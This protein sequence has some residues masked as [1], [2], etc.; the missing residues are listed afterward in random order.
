[1]N[2]I[3]NTRTGSRRL[4]P[5]LATAMLVAGCSAAG[6]SPPSPTTAPS[7]TS[8]PGSSVGTNPSQPPSPS[9]SPAPS[10][11]P[12]PSPKTA[13]TSVTG[14]STCSTFDLGAA[15]P[16]R[17]GARHYARVTVSCEGT[18]SDPRVSGTATG[19]WAVD[20]WGT[21]ENGAF[22]MSGPSTITNA[23]GSWV[24]R[25]TGAWSSERG[26]IVA[27]W[28]KGTGAYAGLGYFALLTGFE[29]MKIRGQIFPGDP[30][31]L[32]GFGPV[33]AAVPS[34][35]MPPPSALAASPTP[36][37]IGLGKVTVTA[38]RSVYEYA[39][40][41][42]SRAGPS[43]SDLYDRG[44]YAGAEIVNDAR[45]GGRF[46]A[47]PWPLQLWGGGGTA[48][49]SGIQWGVSRCDSPGGS[50]QGLGYGIYDEARTAD[51]IVLWAKGDG[52]Y[53]GL[54]YLELI[55]TVDPFDPRPLAEGVMATN[56]LIFPG[57]PPTP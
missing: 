28:Y 30:P 17:N 15:T 16:G 51:T 26:D 24:G 56:G 39:D 57:E 49:G 8:T 42:S 55:T 12:S 11:A 35:N 54:S 47:T 7:P 46:V 22:V 38:G 19:S 31:R 32:A 18:T 44:V 43:G 6:T 52:R 36:Q 9:P 4:L 13:V 41:G 37:A 33:K 29:P 14:M 50:W 27:A 23:G 20:L 10:V 25:L 53:A 2:R 48:I 3:M 34:P 40:L 21:L 45:V 5:V 1:M